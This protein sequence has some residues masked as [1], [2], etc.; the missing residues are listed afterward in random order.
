M[1][2]RTRTCALLLFT[3]AAACSTPAANVK[4]R[5]TEDATRFFTAGPRIGF[6]GDAGLYRY[7]PMMGEW[8]HVATIHSMG[9][10]IDFCET[11]AKA[12]KTQ[13]MQETFT[14]RLLNE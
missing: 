1:S 5:T 8:Q 13:P 3:V 12:L 4:E 14:C 10:D 7:S 11:I 6:S 2:P 9:N